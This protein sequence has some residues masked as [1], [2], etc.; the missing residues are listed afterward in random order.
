MSSYIIEL[1]KWNSDEGKYQKKDDSLLYLDEDGLLLITN[2]DKTKEY[3]R[4]NIRDNY[5]VI[6]SRKKTKHASLHN[7][8]F[9]IDYEMFFEGYKF[10]FRF[11]AR[12]TSSEKNFFDLFTKV[13]D[14][15]EDTE[16]Y[17]S[18]NKRIEGMKTDNGYNG[19]CVEYYDEKESR[20]KYVGEF[21]DNDYDG[22]GEF[23][24]K[25]GNLRLVCKN[26]CSNRPNGKG[27]L[28]IGKNKEV[29]VLNMKDYYSYNSKS[30]N[31]VNNLYKELEPEYEKIMTFIKFD[32]MNINE[33]LYYLFDELQKI[34]ADKTIKK[35]SF[36]NIF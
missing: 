29:R 33:K 27:K 4:V 30:D 8:N 22:E 15:R 23:F 6:L 26:I 35:E 31:Y 18:G 7:T 28:I 32:S 36:F 10:G 17:E 2:E 1:F 14:K 3:L 25:C 12:S 19:V 21:E 5:I 13:K 34:K 16:Y 20:I 24:S 11:D 9:T